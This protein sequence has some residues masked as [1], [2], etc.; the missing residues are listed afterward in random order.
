MGETRNNMFL[1]KVFGLTHSEYQ[2]EQLLFPGIRYGVV[3]FLG[4]PLR[5]EGTGSIRFDVF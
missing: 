4:N 3:L 1:V 5:R 2:G